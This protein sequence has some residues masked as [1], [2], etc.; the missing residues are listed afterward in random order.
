MKFPGI[1]VSQNRFC[2]IFS[3]A[4][5]QCYGVWKG[6]FSLNPLCPLPV[7]DGMDDSLEQETLNFL[8]WMYSCLYSLRIQNVFQSI[9]F[10]DFFY[11][12]S[13]P[14]NISFIFCLFIYVQKTIMH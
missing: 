14:R 13:L 4:N 2:Q 1:L 6:V 9:S 5:C 11:F 10:I 7:F 8:F 3:K 12:F